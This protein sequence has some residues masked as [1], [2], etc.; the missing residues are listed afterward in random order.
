MQPKQLHDYFEADTRQ[1]D[2]AVLNGFRDC[3]P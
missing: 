1:D 3:R 2:N